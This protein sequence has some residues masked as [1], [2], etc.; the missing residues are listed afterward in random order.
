[1]DEITIVHSSDSEDLISIWRE[2]TIILY[3]LYAIKI[4][5]IGKGVVEVVDIDA[6]VLSC[7]TVAENMLNHLSTSMCEDREECIRK[8]YLN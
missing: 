7:Q 6:L 1:M 5:D 2:M 3:M 4:L 8:L